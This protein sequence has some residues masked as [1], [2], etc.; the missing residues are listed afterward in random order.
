MKLGQALKEAG[1]PVGCLAA[2]LLASLILYLTFCRPILEDTA[3]ASIR[4]RTREPHEA[5]AISDL[6][7]AVHQ[8]NDPHSGSQR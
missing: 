3:S 5:P 6:T 4:D 1:V 7:A 8:T 2:I